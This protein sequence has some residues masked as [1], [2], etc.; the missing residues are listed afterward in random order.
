[1][2]LKNDIIFLTIINLLFIIIYVKI[3]TDTNNKLVELNEKITSLQQKELLVFDI[4]QNILKLQ[5]EIYQMNVF[6]SDTYIL[7]YY[8]KRISLQI[9]KIKRLL[10]ILKKGGV[11]TVNKLSNNAYNDKIRKN[12][13]IEKSSST[14][15]I[16]DI[17]TKLK[18]IEMWN[19]NLYKIIKQKTFGFNPDLILKLRRELKLYPSVFYRMIENI[20]RY[21]QLTETQLHKTIKTRDSFVKKNL[22]LQIFIFLLYFIINFV[23]LYS[24]VKNITAIYEELE[25]RLYHDS[26]TSLKNRLSLEK[27]ID[28]YQELLVLDI[29]NFSDINELYG[30]ETGNEFLIKFSELLQKIT[31]YDIYRIGSDEFAIALKEKNHAF[32][33]SF[34]ETLK[35]EHIFI[36]R[37][38]INFTNID[39]KIGVARKKDLLSNVIFALKLAKRKNKNIYIVKECDIIE[40]KKKIQYSLLWT[41]KLKT[42]VQNDKILPFFQPIY[43]SK[44]EIVKYEALMRLEDGGK[45]YPP[46][47]LDIAIKTNLYENMS[48][49]MF[50]KAIS[51]DIPL[52]FNLSYSDIVNP[53]TISFIFNLLKHKNVNLTFEILE[54]ETIEDYD[55]LKSF[56]KEVK[57]HNV[58]I[59]IDDFGSG[60][61]NFQRIIDIMPDFIKIDG[62]L[63]KNIDRDSK[64]LNI[65]KS[66]VFFAKN[67]KIVTVAEFVENEK[68]FDICNNIG[69][70][71]FQGY[72]LSEPLHPDQIYRKGAI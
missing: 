3:N 51:F 50:Q 15:E 43:N 47:Y 57:K 5:S 64:S 34:Y 39:V 26:L 16:N 6:S 32:V 41:Q 31:D 60:Y 21:L 11:Y 72:Y 48:R 61:S 53:N 27:N 20:N 23:L 62:S 29:E 66:M 58:K 30:F 2:K 42:S 35:N 40:E 44:K 19:E 25:Y 65:V 69:I 33:F 52:S 63:I 55:V 46:F 13:L 22:Y 8:K 12:I 24:I 7:D 9:K 14:V 4:S 54:N 36:K 68:I 70:D 59:A 1:M 18:T 67:E 45:F 28:S 49:M 71:L 56:V 17:L 37:L 38:N 10:N